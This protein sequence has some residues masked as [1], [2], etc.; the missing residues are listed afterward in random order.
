MNERDDAP[1]LVSVGIAACVACCAAP[2]LWLVVAAG[3][4]GVL[5]V[6]AFGA[7]GLVAVVPGNVLV[8]RRRSR[9]GGTAGGNRSAVVLAGRGPQDPE[10]P[11]E[12]RH[13]DDGP[14]GP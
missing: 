2:I 8:A 9:R 14:D 5:G 6:V 7:V 12:S 11:D 4:I 3:T 13:D 1:N 10:G